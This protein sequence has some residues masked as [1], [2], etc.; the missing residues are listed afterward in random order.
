MVT[1]IKEYTL[2]NGQIRTPFVAEGESY[3]S[4][5]LTGPTTYTTTITQALRPGRPWQAYYPDNYQCCMDCYVYFPQVE[6][7]YWPVPKSEATCANSSKPLITSQ[8]IL[9]TG[10]AKTAEAR[11]NALFSNSSLTGAVSTVNA[12]GFTFVSPS[13]YVA[14]G[15]VSAGDACGAVGQKYTSVTLGFAPGV[16]QTV[17]SLGKDHYDTTLGTRAFDPAN[18]LCPLD[19]E[20]ATLFVQQ[21][22]LAGIH[23]YRPRIEIPPDLQNLDPKWKSCVVDDYEGIDPPHQLVPAS[24]FEDDPGA[25]TSVSPVQQP[26]PAA[27]APELPKNTGNGNGD[28]P[29]KPSTDPQ[30]DPPKSDHSSGQGVSPNHGESDP[31]EQPDPPS[32]N[33]QGPGEPDDSSGKPAEDN[34]KGNTNPTVVS[35]PDG[36]PANV[37]QQLAAPKPAQPAII[38]QGQTIKQDAP[39]VTIGGK[40]VIYSKGSVYVGGAAAPAPTVGPVPAPVAPQPKQQANPIN[41]GG[42]EFTPIVQPGGQGGGQG[43]AGKPA[44]AKPAVVVQ[45]QTIRESA[46]PVTVNGNKV[47]YSGGSLHLGNTAV[48]VATPKQGQSPL[49]PVVAQ[50]MTFTPIAVSPN[51]DNK[52][53]ANDKQG[54]QARPAVIVKGQTLTEN[55]PPATINGKPIVYSA[56]AIYA[57]GTKAIVPTVSPGQPAPNPINVAGLSFTPKPIPPAGDTVDENGNAPAVI[58]EGHTLREGAPAINVN[59]ANLQYSAGSVYVNKK[60]TAVP[61]PPPAKVGKA[62]D[63]HIVVGGLTVHAGP[64]TKQQQDGGRMP[65]ATVAGKVVREGEDGDVVVDGTTLAPGGGAVMISGTPISA[66]PTGLVI[67]GSETIPL[68]TPQGAAQAVT[69]ISGTPISRDADGDVIVKGKTLSAG[70]PGVTVDGTP[71]SL[72]LSEGRTYLVEGTRTFR[73]PAEITASPSLQLFAETITANAAGEYIVGSRTLSLNSPPITVSGT[74]VSLGRD[75]QGGVILVVGTSTST[76]SSVA[77]TVNPSSQTRKGNGTEASTTLGASETG[78][79][80]SG[81]A[82]AGAGDGGNVV[83]ADSDNGAVGGLPTADSELSYD[84]IAYS[85]LLGSYNRHM[86]LLAVI[87]GGPNPSSGCLFISQGNHHGCTNMPPTRTVRG[88]GHF[89][90]HN[91]V[92]PSPLSGVSY[93]QL[94]NEVPEDITTA[95]FVAV[96]GLLGLQTADKTWFAPGV[97]P[98]TLLGTGTSR[99]GS[100]SR[101]DVVRGLQGT[102]YIGP[103]PRSRYPDLITVNGTE[104]RSTNTSA[105]NFQDSDGQFL[106]T[107]TLG[108]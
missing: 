17:T 78:S 31:P 32:P 52:A 5:T 37:P 44:K 28:D 10:A 2:T 43:G 108:F 71:F 79:E 93:V 38:V 7:Y 47:E 25:I 29:R 77:A 70:G 96:Q 33:P 82:G 9:P 42:F 103:P 91:M 46:P 6:V 13:I 100:R 69:T 55:G 88:P 97:I 83:A 23:T 65:I 21:D 87:T 62:A 81:S 34:P 74:G 16:L 45:G 54:Y 90:V 48:P 41:L 99:F 60:A 94:P 11:Y 4:F 106:D 18:V 107:S 66:N 105:L 67:G 104:Y 56:G 64:S 98:S 75:S 89:L 3:K 95:E 72:A 14:F 19:Y 1:N 49:Q 40:P 27:V 30:A 86:H 8:A 102:A 101:R 92:M 85:S 51:P 76:I 73:L 26:T 22:S 24:G 35:N 20:P 68:P 80:P 12:E 53:P 59:G 15:D 39:P 50:G 61:I 84:A 57:V 63:E 36:L 58:I